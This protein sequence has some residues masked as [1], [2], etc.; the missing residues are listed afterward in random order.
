MTD[1]AKLSEYQDA[2]IELL[3][4]GMSEGEVM[5]HLQTDKRFE[6]YRDYVSQFDPDMVAVASE[7]ICKWAIRKPDQ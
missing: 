5:Q 3:A 6:Y 4:S 2:L 7:L 1:Q